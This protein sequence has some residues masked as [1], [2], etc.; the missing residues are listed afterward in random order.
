MHTDVCGHH[1][2]K[3]G[4]AFVVTALA[5]KRTAEAVTTNLVAP[6]Y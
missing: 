5:V 4:E 6:E 3:L 1:L 2:K